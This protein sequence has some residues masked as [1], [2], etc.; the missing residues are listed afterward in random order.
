[1][2]LDGIRV[3]P[4]TRSARPTPSGSRSTCVGRTGHGSRTCWP[5]PNT[6]REDPITLEPS[7]TGRCCLL[8]HNPPG[9]WNW[10]KSFGDLVK[11]G[12]IDLSLGLLG[13]AERRSRRDGTG[14]QTGP[15]RR[16][17][18]LT[19][20][21]DTLQKGGDVMDFGIIGEIVREPDPPG[22]DNRRWIDLIREHPNLVPPEPVEGISPFTKKRMTIK[23]LPDV[24]RVVLTKLICATC[25][26]ARVRP[27]RRRLRPPAGR[28][29]AAQGHS[30]GVRS[31]VG[32]GGKNKDAARNTTT[33]L[34]A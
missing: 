20:N 9:F 5:S 21:P 28:L 4:P 3:Y 2:D 22:I 15:F 32:E 29:R 30:G 12:L 26:P 1:M 14:C 16:G 8:S 11:I 10:L 34:V 17:R 7:G 23:P 33:P 13:M 19:R 6:P 18:S 25:K 27:A 24:A 31:G